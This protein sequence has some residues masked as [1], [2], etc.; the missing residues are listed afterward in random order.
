MPFTPKVWR[1]RP[2]APNVGETLKDYELRLAIYAAA[3]P[4]LVTPIDADALEDIE[5]RLAE[6]ADLTGLADI[7]VEAFGAEAGRYVTD[8]YIEGQTAILVSA[9]ASFAAGDVG[10][11]VTVANAGIPPGSTSDPVPLVTTILSV[12]SATSATLAVA[13]G[14]TVG[15]AHVT[16][17]ADNRAALDD[18]YEA[19]GV[20]GVVFYPPGVW[21]T[22]GNPASV[23]GAFSTGI[24][25]TIKADFSALDAE[26]LGVLRG[27]TEVILSGLTVDYDVPTIV[28][29]IS[30]LDELNARLRRTD[31]QFLY[32]L[33]NTR[34]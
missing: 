26:L 12:Q 30:A 7:N 17:G 13:A 31:A 28:G 24:G 27:D 23:S 6:Y 33:H 11:R 1:D 20:G 16:I 15:D 34:S 19:A 14:R 9:T 4:D 5:T 18:A 22:S 25:A 2:F 8:A 32:T 21:L 10:E 3:N 29:E